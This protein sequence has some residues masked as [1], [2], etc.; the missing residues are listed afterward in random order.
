MDY[1]KR[2]KN[3]QKLIKINYKLILHMYNKIANKCS[4]SNLYNLPKVIEK[5]KMY[6]INVENKMLKG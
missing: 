1:N 3:V 2:K 5:Q 6:N 4:A